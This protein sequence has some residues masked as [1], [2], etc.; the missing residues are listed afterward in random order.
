MPL[1]F[2]PNNNDDNTLTVGVQ[3]LSRPDVSQ[4]STLYFGVSQIHG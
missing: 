2:F 3:I 4:D 1:H